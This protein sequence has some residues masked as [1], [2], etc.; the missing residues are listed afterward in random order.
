[1]AVASQTEQNA[2]FIHTLGPAI[3]E[4]TQL[5]GV[6]RRRIHVDKGLPRLDP[7][8][9]AGHNQPHKFRAGSAATHVA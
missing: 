1:M 6:E 9:I 4:R 8:A 7:G 3:A 2:A 5:L